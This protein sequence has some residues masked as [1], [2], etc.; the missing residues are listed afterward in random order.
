MQTIAEVAESLVGTPFRHQGRRP[1][2]GLDCVGVVYAA[3]RG[4]GV[5]VEDFRSYLRMPSADVL[6][7]EMGKRFRRIE[8]AAAS[9]GDIIV[10]GGKSGGRHVGVIVSPDHY[11]ESRSGRAVTRTRIA[12][13]LI[14]SAFRVGR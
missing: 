14:V 1:G 8:P 5:Q 10:I 12:R 9:A 3:C 7:Q 13:E 11:V 6:D 2:V 4:A